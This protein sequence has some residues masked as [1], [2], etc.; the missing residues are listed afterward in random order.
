MASDHK[1]YGKRGP[2]DAAMKKVATEFGDR[3]NWMNDSVTTRSGECVFAIGTCTYGDRSLQGAIAKT[4]IVTQ[5]QN[6]SLIVL[7]GY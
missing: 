4:G 7:I 3:S 5:T 1:F 6:N 2:R